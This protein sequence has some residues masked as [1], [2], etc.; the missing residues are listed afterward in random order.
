MLVRLCPLMNR[1][2]FLAL[3]AAGLAFGLAGCATPS[4]KP[5]A[6]TR[7]YEMRIYYAPPGKLEDLHARFRDHTTKLFPK[8]GIQNIGYWV[9]VDNSEN[10]LV[11]LLAYPSREAR[12]ASWK[13]FM[14]DPEW[15][16]VQKKTEANGR[17]VAKVESFFLNTTDFSPAVKTGNVS[18]GGVFE[19][20]TYT[21]PEGRL[22]NLDARF[23]DHT[24]KLFAKHG[25]NNWGYFH[26]TSD[27]PGASTTLLYFVTHKSQDGAKASFGAFGQDP[28]WK[29]VK[30]ESEKNAGG[31]LTVEG[32]VKS[33]FLVPTD[34]SP[35]K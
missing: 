25:I 7:V 5:V 11:Y 14:A 22:P 3:S 6:D 24:V 23:R 27:Q 34:Y 18:K 10:K 32:G 31:S 20:R 8:H 4:T 33:Q 9:P 17:I 29:A 15:K 16:A 13:A 26:K 12:E 1:S 19:L 21:T 2:F 35:T 30:A 28:E